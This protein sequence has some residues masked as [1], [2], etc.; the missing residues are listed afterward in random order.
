MVP[1]LAYRPLS[2]RGTRIRR[3]SPLRAAERAAPASSLS[4]AM[5]TTMPGRTTPLVSGSRGRLRVWS[6]SIAPFRTLQRG[7]LF[8]D[9]AITTASGGALAAHAA[10]LLGGR[11][12]PDA[13]GLAVADRVV[14]ALGAHRA[15]GADRQ[16]L[17]LLGS[18]G[19][20]E[21]LGVSTATRGL[22]CP[23]SL[24]HDRHNAP[25]LKAIS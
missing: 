3:P 20:K 12:A 2:R 13:V 14:E 16:R 5:V 18:G 6:S 8:L 11:A 25:P 7:W 15:R 17:G 21:D 22:I 23:R 24:F 10:A 1:T 9:A 19:R 4:T